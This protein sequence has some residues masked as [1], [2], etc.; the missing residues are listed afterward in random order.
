LAQA[1]ALLKFLAL[2]VL[3]VDL[4]VLVMARFQHAL[5]GLK[6]DDVLASIREI[7]TAKPYLCGP[8][9]DLASEVAVVIQEAEA[10]EFLNQQA[11][12]AE[13]QWSK[14]KGKGKDKGQEKGK[15]T[16]KGH[17]KGPRLDGEYYANGRRFEG[18]IKSYV[19][20]Q[21]YGF[22]A[23]DELFNAFGSDVFL[24]GYAV[25][26]ELEIGASVS[27]TV[28]LN[29][30]GK[31]QAF[32]LGPP[33]GQALAVEQSFVSCAGEH[34]F[35]GVIKSYVAKSQY[36]FISCPELFSMFGC[37]AFV[38]SKSIPAVFEIG[39]ACS[40]TVQ[41]NKEG[42]PQAYE[43]KVESEHRGAKRKQMA[44]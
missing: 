32:D 6:D 12:A 21:N 43:V 1:E 35:Y 38:T 28:K 42:K 26:A 4:P 33:G 24:A 29:K 19:A 11:A 9:M 30:S 22:V 41:P 7:L 25:T 39:D 10:Q 40:F 2:H 27:F 5:Q 15:D 13:A 23:C 20:K 8:V 18:T 3:N 16:G 36:G 37:D 44:W 34:R 31:P 14:G 17:G